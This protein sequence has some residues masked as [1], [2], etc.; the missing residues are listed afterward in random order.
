[1]PLLST[2]ATIAAIVGGSATAATSI[3]G[4]TQGGGSPSQPPPPPPKTAAQNVTDEVAR[5]G[6]DALI[7]RQ[8]Q[9]GLQSN[10]GGSLSDQ[11]YQ[12]QDSQ[13]AGLPGEF[14]S[15]GFDLNSILKLIGGGSGGSGNPTDLM[16]LATGSGGG[17]ITG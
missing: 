4:A 2:L 7:A 10:T 17:S 14:G 3:Y 9:P 15:G 6:Q 1:M 5:R 8:Q 13:M 11:S 16:A 12:T